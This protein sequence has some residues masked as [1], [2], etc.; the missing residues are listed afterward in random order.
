MQAFIKFTDANILKRKDGRDKIDWAIPVAVLLN[1]IA[2]SIVLSCWHLPF[3]LPQHQSYL[4]FLL[5][6]LLLWYCDI[7]CLSIAVGIYYSVG[8]RML[9]ENYIVV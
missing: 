6:C 8:T 4:H 3:Q 9:I 7:P 2:S 1:T 5:P